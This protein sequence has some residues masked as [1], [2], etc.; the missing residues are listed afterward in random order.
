VRNAI[1]FGNKEIV[2]GLIDKV[3]VL[4]NGGELIQVKI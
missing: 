2:S 3:D 4:A 1:V